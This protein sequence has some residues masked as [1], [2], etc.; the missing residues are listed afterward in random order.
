MVHYFFLEWKCSPEFLLGHLIG[1][2]SDLVLAAI[3]SSVEK[4]LLMKTLLNK[5]QHFPAT[6]IKSALLADANRR[7]DQHLDKDIGDV[8]RQYIGTQL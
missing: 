6:Q 3:L 1:T 2:L 8:L 7:P 5:L 4:A